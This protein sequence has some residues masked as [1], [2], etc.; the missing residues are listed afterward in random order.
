MG[1]GKTAVAKAK[2]NL[3][4]TIYISIHSLLEYMIRMVVINIKLFWF[5]TVLKNFPC[6]VG[7]SGLMRNGNRCEMPE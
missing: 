1:S 7:D 6:S 5:G 3:N 4:Q 2:R